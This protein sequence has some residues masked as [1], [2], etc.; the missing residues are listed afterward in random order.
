MTN[1]NFDS[2]A[3]KWWARDGEFRLL[4]D[5]N[6]LRIQFANSCI[7]GLQGKRIADVGCGG[8]IFAEAAARAG[9]R[10]VGVD[11]SAEAI[12]AARSHA[13]GG[14]V[15]ID[16]RAGESSSL[17]ESEGGRFDAV[18]C[19]EMLEHVDDSASVVADCAALLRPK[20]DLILSTVNR[21]PAAYVGMILVLER[22]LKLMPP[23]MHEYRRFITPAELAGRCRDAGLKIK[24]TAGLRYDFFGRHYYL[25]PGR[26][27]TNYF[28][29]AKRDD[30]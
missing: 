5:I 7:G 26:A 28:M 13:E 30:N 2:F 27:G 11:I 18:V 14:G 10:V 19:F 17:V 23:G 9:A 29:H 16:Y 4:H 22:A 12:A 20:G 21:T 1:S 3:A 24:K 15:E 8:G 6:P 25:S